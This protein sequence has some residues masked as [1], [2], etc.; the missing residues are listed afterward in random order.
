MK[1]LQKTVLAAA[2][3]TGDFRLPLMV[4]DKINSHHST[5]DL[6]TD[7]N[8]RCVFNEYLPITNESGSARKGTSVP[9]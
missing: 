1:R 5:T 2:N 4:I 7:G 3:A 8:I 6:Q 9:F